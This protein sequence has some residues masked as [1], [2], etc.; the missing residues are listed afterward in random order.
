ML[1]KISNSIL[2]TKTFY[3]N[4]M[5]KYNN[6]YYKQKSMKNFFVPQCIDYIIIAFMR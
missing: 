5:T 3:S 2:D 1:N 6:L 4:Q